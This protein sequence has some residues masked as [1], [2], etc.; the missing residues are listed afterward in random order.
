MLSNNQLI[1]SDYILCWV[2][3]W[4]YI[5]IYIYNVRF[6]YAYIYTCKKQKNCLQ[7]LL[8]R[9]ELCVCVWKGG[10]YFLLYMLLYCLNFFFYSSA[11][12]AFIINKFKVFQKEMLIFCPLVI[13]C[14]VVVKT[15]NN[16]LNGSWDSIIQNNSALTDRLNNL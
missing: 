14:T 9:N 13:Q 11:C 15:L 1:V 4:N 5:Y 8:L 3:M 2:R 7:W 6:I 10:F 16:T 12:M